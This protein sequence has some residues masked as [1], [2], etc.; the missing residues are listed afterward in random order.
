MKDAE[1]CCT[2]RNAS[3][4]S[5]SNAD[6]VF[7]GLIGGGA[8]VALFV[9]LGI[10]LWKRSVRLN[11]LKR[12]AERAAQLRQYLAGGESST[13][14]PDYPNEVP[15]SWASRTLSRLRAW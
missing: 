12:E 4:R 11:D 9:F 6:S 5:R 2:A 3:N 13:D 8:A 14:D 15:A 10:I 1:A 7:Y